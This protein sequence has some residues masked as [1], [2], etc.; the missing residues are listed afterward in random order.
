[1][2]F[3]CTMHPDLPETNEENYIGEWLM[4]KERRKA[5]KDFYN[6]KHN[7]PLSIEHKA[8]NKYGSM[9]PANERAGKILDLFL[10]KDGHMIAKCHLFSENKESF[11]RINYGSHVNKEKWG[12]SPRID[13][14]MPDGLSGKI[15]KHITHLALTLTPYFDKY[16]TYI[17]DWNTNEKTMDAV[18]QRKYYKENDGKCF[19]MPEL[20]NKIDYSMNL[21]YKKKNNGML[22]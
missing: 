1:M 5:I 21:L 10:D 2:Y 16:G 11:K 6:E 19:A 8:D 9:T 18:I 13:W 14:C 7:I 22:L 4:L 12:V 17:H 15:N 20:K 3:L